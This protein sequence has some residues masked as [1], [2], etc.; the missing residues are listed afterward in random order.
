MNLKNEIRI[1]RIATL[2]KADSEAL[3]KRIAND[4][5]ELGALASGTVDCTSPNKDGLLTFKQSSGSVKK[6]KETHALR[7]IAISNRLAELEELGFTVTAG[8]LDANLS[9]TED[10]A[11]GAADWLTA[12][13]AEREAKKETVEA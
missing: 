9:K 13:R 5:R 10:Y 4:I 11:T 6:V 8:T 12:K 7:L 1:T 2:V 3:T